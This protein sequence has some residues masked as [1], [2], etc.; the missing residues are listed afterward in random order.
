M[1]LKNHDVQ[2]DGKLGNSRFHW[3]SRIFSGETWTWNFGRLRYS[4]LQHFIF[5]TFWCRDSPLDS[6]LN[7][8]PQWK[9]YSFHW[10]VSLLLS[11]VVQFVEW[12][13]V[14][15]HGACLNL[16]GGWSLAMVCA[17]HDVVL[18]RFWRA[19]SQLLLSSYNDVA[20][21]YI[22]SFGVYMAEAVVSCTK[23]ESSESYEALFSIN[24]S[25]G[26]G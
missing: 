15:R 24:Y 26:P 12:R 8:S 7:N 17:L 10:R 22:C 23:L 21:Q 6:R 16:R 9:Y 11:V 1:T 2:L 3:K 18:F 13:F 4:T 19:L 20:G 25:T 14:S 5:D